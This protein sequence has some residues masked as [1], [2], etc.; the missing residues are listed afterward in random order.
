MR[1]AIKWV[2]GWFAF[3]SWSYEKIVVSSATACTQ[4]GVEWP[5]PLGPTLIAVGNTTGIL[6]PDCSLQ[7]YF[8]LVV[9]ATNESTVEITWGNISYIDSFPPT[10]SRLFLTGSR[11]LEFDFPND[12]H[13]HHIAFDVNE[14]KSLE[15]FHFSQTVTSLNLG[16]NRLSK[17]LPGQLPSS[18]T[19]LDVRANKFKSP[20]SIA[21][22]S[23]LET[24]II[25]ENLFSSEETLT[26]PP[27]LR[28]LRLDYCG[29]S[30][31]DNLVLPSLHALSIDGNP[32]GNIDWMELPPSL[33]DFS[34]VGCSLRSAPQTSFPSTLS[35]LALNNNTFRVLGNLTLPKAITYLN[36]SYC[37][38]E[39][40]MGTV[41]PSTLEFLD[42]RGNP[43]KE[44]E[45]SKND[46]MVLRAMG[47]N[48]IVDTMYNTKCSDPDAVKQD[49]RAGVVACVIDDN[50]YGIKYEYDGS[51]WESQTAAPA[52][53]P[54]ILPSA[55]QPAI[56]TTRADPD[57]QWTKFAM[58]G[59]IGIVGAA[60][61]VFVVDIC[62]TRR[63]ATKTQAPESVYNTQPVTSLSMGTHGMVDEQLNDIRNDKE[64]AM[65]R[66]PQDEIVLERYLGSGG[67]ATTHLAW[68]RG[69]LPVV[70]KQLRPESAKDSARVAAFMDEIRLMIQ[71]AHP[72]IVYFI[73]MTWSTLVD[74][75]IVLEYMPNGDLM[76]MLQS[77]RGSSPS[78]S[79]N[80]EWLQSR[81]SG[82]RSQ[83]SKSTI[84]LDVVEALV[85]LH[86]FDPPI[87]H[88][89]VKARNVL[90]NE[91]YVA[92]LSD[93]GI[94]REMTIEETM[95][96][97]VGTA[98]WMAPE[99]LR[100]ERYDV[101]ADIYSFGVLMSELDTSLP[102]YALEY[103]PPQ[104]AS[105]WSNRP[106][107]AGIA[108]L[109]SSG[110]IQPFFSPDC[111]TDIL[112]IANRCLNQDPRQRPTAVQ[113]HFELRR[114]IMGARA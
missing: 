111:P 84:S 76:S 113:L 48:F 104:V 36:L 78:Q 64:L 74:I 3:A 27:T 83:P 81:L 56:T 10:A 80:L 9:D 67:C 114:W 43:L 85:Y 46:L 54:G 47:E 35:Y 79:P 51:E 13:L 110:Q 23:K 87:I 106:T 1:F 12:T 31:T 72:K 34:A 94:S 4:D 71:L 41:I 73:G 68:L 103:A 89:D 97:G 16:Y 11:L 55:T 28:A 108:L 14:I 6:Y 52:T 91:T 44:L 22:P 45:I 93:F 60:F 5:A 24:L 18:L 30:S 82:L 98:A 66:I 70:I 75:A 26:F 20:S 2:L 100:G 69:D 42:L 90:L 86:S 17:I 92:K 61:M 58:F 8:D 105:Q 88:R 77:P 25:A 59:L 15:N 102:P 39:R 19:W 29:L 96:L 53:D 101:K 7:G 50:D 95:S 112:D 99:V 21:Y 63:K 38:I 40:F 62:R 65:F 37:S 107:Q 109:V 33:Q 49:V 57:N 32:L